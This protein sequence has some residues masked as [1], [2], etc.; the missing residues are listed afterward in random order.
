MGKCLLLFTRFCR[1]EISSQDEL[2]LVRNTGLK[3][4]PGM[5][6]RKKTNEHFIP[7]LNFAMSMLLLDF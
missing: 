4:H 3:F 6:K 2:I 5:T 1:D 7:G